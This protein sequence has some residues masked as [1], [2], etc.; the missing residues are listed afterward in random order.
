[1]SDMRNCAEAAV[2]K[3]QGPVFLLGS[4]V[5]AG[6]HGTSPNLAKLVD[7]DPVHTTDF[8]R[9]YA[10]ILDQWLDCP[11][12]PILGKR[13]APLDLLQRT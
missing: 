1:M 6:I 9:I 2:T 13:F 3:E 4:R 5:N 11:S 10:T 8:R 12:E 7:G